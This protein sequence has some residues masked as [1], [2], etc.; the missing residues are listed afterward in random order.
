VGTGRV[1]GDGNVAFGG[2]MTVGSSGA[3]GDAAYLSKSA[4]N[5]TIEPGHFQNNLNES[6]SSA[7]APYT[8]GASLVAPAGPIGGTNYTWVAGNTNNYYYSGDFQLSG[9]QSMIVTSAVTLYVKG[10]VNISGSGFIYLTPN[11]SLTLYIYGPSAQISGSGVVNGSQN[12]ANFSL[13]GLPTLTSGNY[14]GSSKFIGTVYAPNADWTLSG[15]AGAY[16]AVVANSFNLSG[17][18]NLHYDEGLSSKGKAPYYFTSW[19]EL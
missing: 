10:S 7:S 11:A 6:F 13:I 18:M 1:Y 17:G 12:A 4:N 15:S 9:G 2:T 16:G 5:G 14:S 8:N 3:V 19:Q